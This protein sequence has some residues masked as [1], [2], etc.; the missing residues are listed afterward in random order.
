[1]ARELATCI[2]CH[3]LWLEYAIATAQHIEAIARGVA[4]E[5]EAA[6]VKWQQARQQITEHEKSFVHMESA[7]LPAVATKASARPMRPR[8]EAS[9]M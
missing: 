1:M 9:Y 3:Y 5:V 8:R 4:G 7:P 2:D 6:L